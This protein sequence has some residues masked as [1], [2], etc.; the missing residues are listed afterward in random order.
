MRLMLGFL[1]A[2]CVAT[3]HLTA[4]AGGVPKTGGWSCGDGSYY[5]SPD[6][7]CA[8]IAVIDKWK[9]SRVGKSSDTSAICVFSNNGANWY[10]GTTT[11][12]KYTCPTLYPVTGPDGLCWK[13]PPVACK[14]GTYADSEEL[15]PV[16]PPPSTTS[17]STTTT[18]AT[19]T[20]GTSSGS[21]TGGTTTST[22]DPT[23]TGTSTTTGSTSSTSGTTTGTTSGSS[24]GTTTGTTSTGDGSG[25][26]TG[27]TTTTTGGTSTTTTTGA[28]TTGATTTGATTTTTGATTTSTSTG[29]TS[30]GSTSTGSMPTGNTTTTGNSDG[31][32]PNSFCKK[33]PTLNI[34]QNSTVSGECA[35]TTCTGDAITCAI[36]QEQR[37]ANCE[38]KERNSHSDLSTAI[39][40]G[41]DPQAESLPSLEKANVIELNNTPNS[42]SPWLGSS[43]F[44]DQSFELMNQTLVIRFS[45]LCDGLIAFRG[46]VM[47]IAGLA[48]FKMVSRSVLS[49]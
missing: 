35:A 19:G 33:N 39:L 41:A 24:T 9:Y 8:C 43:C 32:D 12:Y 16:P 22:G 30:N 5:A 40:N 23:G 28:T 15:C 4:Y 45:K 18:G 17:S 38:A 36:L 3:V 42:P 1:L 46:L 44:A 11:S 10:E 13:A 49:A 14:D 25:T 37:K 47:L 26:S 6:G 29:T 7:A 34:C 27:T 20:T 31:S 2:L 48:S 21:S